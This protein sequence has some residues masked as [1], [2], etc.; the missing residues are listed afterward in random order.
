V[1]LGFFVLVLE[2]AFLPGI[3][4]RPNA[5]RF[6]DVQD[7]RKKCLFEDDD[8]DEDEDEDENGR[9]LSWATARRVYRHYTSFA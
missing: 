4:K 2:S 9:G 5:P 6:S 8:E 3:F 7:A 1:G